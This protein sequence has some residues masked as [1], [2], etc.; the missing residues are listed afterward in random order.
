VT[1]VDVA[2]PT[3][4]LAIG[5]HPDDIEFGCG[6]TLGVLMVRG[7]EAVLEDVDVVGGAIGPHQR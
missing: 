1:T 4:A 3:R 2:A 7:S 5:A 6:A